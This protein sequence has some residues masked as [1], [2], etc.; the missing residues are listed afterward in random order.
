MCIYF[1]IQY[2]FLDEGSTSVYPTENTTEGTYNPSSKP[3]FRWQFKY[4]CL[5][6][7]QVPKSANVSKAQNH[8]CVYKQCV[9]S[10]V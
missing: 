2:D 1:I 10:V 9:A 7:Q 5:K 6:G 3:D 8:H 4:A